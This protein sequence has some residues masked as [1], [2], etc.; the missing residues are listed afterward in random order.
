MLQLQLL[1]PGCRLLASTCLKWIEWGLE[2]DDLLF[3]LGVK[4]DSTYFSLD[5]I[6]T[7]VIKAFKGSPDYCSNS[8]V[9][10]QEMFLP[11]H[12]NVISLCQIRDGDGTLASYLLVRA[13][14]AKLGPVANVHFVVCAP[15]IVLG[16][17]VVL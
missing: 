17:E 4:I 5:L 13:E 12:E 10:D 1:E 6:E 7:D 16:E 15:V 2:G 14:S 9:W 8:V 3:A 11:S